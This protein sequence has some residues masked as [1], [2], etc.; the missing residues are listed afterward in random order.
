MAYND[1]ELVFTNVP[2]LWSATVALTST[3]DPVSAI[4]DVTPIAF[5]EASA[6]VGSLKD[7]NGAGR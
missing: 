7:V 4:D 1:S 5:E 2:M 6:A 3:G